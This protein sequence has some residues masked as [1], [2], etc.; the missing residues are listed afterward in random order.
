MEETKKDTNLSPELG[1]LYAIINRVANGETMLPKTMYR[2]VHLSKKLKYSAFEAKSDHLRLYLITE[3]ETGLIFIIGGKKT[4]QY[5]ND[6]DNLEK[7]IKEYTQF[8]H[9]KK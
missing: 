6:L 7:I 8:K 9:N 5:S 1:D 2:K 4:K 3:K